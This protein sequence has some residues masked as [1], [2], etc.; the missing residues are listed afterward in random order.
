MI[1][2]NNAFDQPL[3]GEAFAD[4]HFFGD[5]FL[6]LCH[7]ADEIAAYGSRLDGALEQWSE[8]VASMPPEWLFLDANEAV[9]VNFN[10]EDV[11]AVLCEHRGE[12]FWSW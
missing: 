9:P 11:L 1:D 10:F 4:A 8:I 3:T 2:H 12:G 6:A 7:D 5:Q